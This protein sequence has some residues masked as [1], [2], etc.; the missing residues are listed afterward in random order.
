MVSRF[1]FLFFFWGGGGGCSSLADNSNF[2][3]FAHPAPD[4]PGGVG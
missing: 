2:L 4:F 3:A 1:F